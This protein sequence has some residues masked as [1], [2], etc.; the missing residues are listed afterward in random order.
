MESKKSSVSTIIKDSAQLDR[1]ITRITYQILDNHNGAEHLAI[2][3]IKDRGEI[4]AQRIVKKIKEIEKLDI[5][6]GVVDPT[7]YRD[8]FIHTPELPLSRYTQLSFN[9]EAVTIILVDDI[10]GTGRTIRAAIDCILDFGRPINIEVA[11]L[12][13]RKANEFPIVAK[14]VGRKTYIEPNKKLIVHVK[15]RDGEDKIYCTS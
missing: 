11:V 4:F 10:L 2:V 8:D 9:I 7:L 13:D 6:L 5:P 3:G 1:I 12:C 14:Y 15:E